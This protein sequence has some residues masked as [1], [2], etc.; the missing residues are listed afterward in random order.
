MTASTS[1]LTN[2]PAPTSPQLIRQMRSERIKITSTKTWWLFGLGLTLLTG[3]SVTVNVLQTHDDIAHNNSATQMTTD[4]ANVFTSGQ[5]FGGLFVL[6]LAI[7]IVTNEFYHQTATST[8]LATPH[9][10]VVILGKFVVAMIAAAVAWL[11]TTV[12][13]LVVGLLFFHAEGIS[14]GLGT[15]GVG[16]AML[17]NVMVFALWGVFGVGFAAL[18]RSQIGATVT[19]VLLYTIGTLA[20]ELIFALIHQ[21]VWHSRHVYQALVLVPGIAAEVAVSPTPVTFEGA[22]IPWW[23]GV[24][25]L[26]AYG[27][28][29]GVVGTLILR[30]RDIS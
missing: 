9:R 20:V 7:L 17:V 22:S 5:Y 6:L 8:F 25:V 18:I 24:I 26:L 15:W 12:I 14:S 21:Y 1:T 2:I 29:M 10:S 27:V 23:S 19:A 28:V 13:S 3:A 30:K 4:A 11:L 16:R